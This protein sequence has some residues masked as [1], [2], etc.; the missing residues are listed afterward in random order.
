MLSRSSRKRSFVKAITYRGIIICLDFL[1]IYVLTGKV[2][3]AAAFMIVTT[4]TPPLPISCMSA[5]GLA[6]SGAWSFRKNLE[7]N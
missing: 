4:S 5:Y 2:T 7:I 3:T 1:V 6:S